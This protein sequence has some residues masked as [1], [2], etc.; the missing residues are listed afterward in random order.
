MFIWLLFR[1]SMYASS[2]SALFMPFWCSTSTVLHI[3]EKRAEYFGVWPTAI[4]C[5]VNQHLR[6]LVALKQKL[7]VYQSM[8]ATVVYIIRYGSQAQII[9]VAVM[10]AIQLLHCMM[11]IRY[12]YLW[13]ALMSGTLVCIPHLTTPPC[14]AIMT[15]Y[16]RN[17]MPKYTWQ[18]HDSCHY[19]KTECG[20]ITHGPT[21]TN[22]PRLSRVQVDASTVLR[23]R[24]MVCSEAAAYFTEQITIF[25]VFWV[26]QESTG[27]SCS[28]HKQSTDTQT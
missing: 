23:N 28:W 1:I 20:G 24:S 19:I 15:S 3:Q 22:A 4:V 7:S 5:W 11:R 6:G 18:Q 21:L 9:S 2:D 16:R 8:H 17:I 27:D 26:K 25:S 14:C 12:K 10:V 13:H